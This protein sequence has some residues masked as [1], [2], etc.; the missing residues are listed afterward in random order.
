[1]PSND[2]TRRTFYVS[3]INLLGALVT[4]A[5]A[6]P[7]ALYLAIRPKTADDSNW[8]EVTDF[9]Q[10]KVNTPVE[11]LYDH[12]RV[13]GWETVAEKSSAWVVRTED[14]NVVA[15]KPAC[16]H[17]ACAYHWENQGKKFLCPCHGSE[18]SVDGKVLAG[19]APRPLDRFLTKVEGGKVLIGSQ[20][21]KG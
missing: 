12:K 15:Y 8:I 9:S 4:A 3:F 13:D 17:L 10:L 7:A 20:V 1:M 14:H 18:F 21:E 11:V 2:Q 19:P 5:I 16:T 6:V